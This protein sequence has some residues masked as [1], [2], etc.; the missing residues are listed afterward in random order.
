MSRKYLKR[1]LIVLI[2][3]LIVL[4]VFSLTPLPRAS[5]ANCGLIEGN[6]ED[7]KAGGGP[8]DILVKISGNN[9]YYYIN[10]GLENG[11]NL[12]V[13]TKQIKDKPAKVY[14]IKHWSLFNFNAMTRHIGRIETGQAIVYNEW[15]QE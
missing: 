14:Y 5:A 11:V 6:V 13:L 9:G 15:K 8:G 2:A 3:I 12:D 7:V 10:R 4:L 1:S